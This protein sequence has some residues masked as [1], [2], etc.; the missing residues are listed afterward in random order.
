MRWQKDRLIKRI[1]ELGRILADPEV[2]TDP[3]KQR[4]YSKEFKELNA[5]LARIERYEI[6]TREYQETEELLKDPELKEEAASELKRI[7]RRQP[8]SDP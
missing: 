7:R 8:D 3:L 2:A 6:L 4:R 1:N 5:D